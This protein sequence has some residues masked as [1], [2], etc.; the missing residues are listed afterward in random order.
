MT[1][2]LSAEEVGRY[3]IMLSLTSF[4][5]LLL[6]GPMGHYVN[7]KLLVWQQYG[8]IMRNLPLYWIYL[9]G[10]T[11]VAFLILLPIKVFAGINIEISWFWIMIIVAGNILCNTANLTI[12]T[13]LNLLGNRIWYFTFTLLTLWGGLGLS[14]LFIYRI[15]AKAEYWLLGLIISQ[16][17]V[18]VLAYWYL[19]R[20][21]DLLKNDTT[22]KFT[23]KLKTL[24]KIET[25]LPPLQF[26]WPLSIVAGLSWVQ[27]QSYRFVLSHFGG[28]EVLGLFAVGYGLATAI[29][30]AFQQV[31]NIYYG[32]IFY[33]AISSQNSEQRRVSWNKMAAYLFPGAIIMTSFI[34][35][36]APYLTRLLVTTEFLD[37]AQ[38]LLWGALTQLAFVVGSN[39]QL[40]A[41]AEMKTT[42]LIP[43]GI[44]GAIVALTCI[45]V[46]VQWDPQ[47]GTGIGLTAAGFTV[48]VHLAIQLHKQV[49]YQLPWKRL[50]ISLAFSTPLLIILLLYI[51][52]LISKPSY[53]QSI[54]II[55][56]AGVYFLIVQ[57]LLATRWHKLA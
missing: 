21:S 37:S 7:R 22:L 31:F 5:A 11:T 46:L 45:L 29:M 1:A 33:K 23:R 34:I 15:G 9:V 38:F 4:F 3:Y 17:A 42:W 25:L 50:F 12:T 18:F 14:A 10:C 47:L 49:P 20:S 51:N 57:Y 53:A 16:F 39:M 24:P 56:F 30:A 28:L 27:T 13:T 26:A 40:I 8:T 2:L 36:C 44:T 43:S 32:P 6:V 55:T 19:A 54:I 35:A 52:P 41:H 48:V